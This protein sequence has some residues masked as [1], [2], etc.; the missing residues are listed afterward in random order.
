MTVEMDTRDVTPWLRGIKIELLEDGFRAFELRFSAWHSFNSDNYWDIYE[1]FDKDTNPYESITIRRGRLLVDHE[2]L[3]TVNPVRPP[4]LVANGR[5]AGWFARRRRPRETIVLVPNST[6]VDDD[7]QTALADYSHKNPGRPVGQVRVWRGVDTIGQACIRLIRA[8]G[9]NC[10]YRL[11]D[12]PLTPYVIDP[13]ISYWSAVNRLSDP[14]AP[15]RYYQ[16]WSNTWV[17]QDAAEPLM[18]DGPPLGIPEDEMKHLQA[19]PRTRPYPAR[20]LVRFPPWR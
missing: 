2:R 12:H 11:P 8:A 16:R 1:S 5:E 4:Y 7:V 9:L 18:G 19:I 15:V 20:I 10:S 6:T 17:I 3:I 14:W 13:T